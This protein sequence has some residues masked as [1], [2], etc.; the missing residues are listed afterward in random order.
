[1]KCS[2]GSIQQR[3]LGSAIVKTEQI[4]YDIS[5]DPQV[6]QPLLDVLDLK[7]VVRIV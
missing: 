6:I 7:C 2:D 1:M 4:K 3:I 5:V